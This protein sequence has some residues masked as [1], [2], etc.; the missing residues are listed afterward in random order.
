MKRKENLRG[1]FCRGKGYLDNKP[2]KKWLMHT[3]N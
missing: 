1:P 3:I 2:P